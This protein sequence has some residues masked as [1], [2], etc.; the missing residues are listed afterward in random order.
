MKLQN[1][2]LSR[3]YHYSKFFLIRIVMLERVEHLG[4]ST[5]EELLGYNA[6]YLRIKVI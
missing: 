3:H 1:I 4:E 2:M 6:T 5:E